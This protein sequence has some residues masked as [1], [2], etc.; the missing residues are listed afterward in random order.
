MDGI[1]K[2]AVGVE[3]EKNTVLY[4][5]PSSEYEGF[6]MSYVLITKQDSVDC[7]TAW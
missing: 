3:S 5:P 2:V 6:M 1:I 4:Q 7:R